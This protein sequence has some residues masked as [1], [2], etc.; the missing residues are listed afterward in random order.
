MP[1]ETVRCYNKGCGAEFVEHENDDSKCVHHPGQPVFHDAMKGWSCCNKK[2]TDFTEFLNIKGCTVGRHSNVK[3][4]EPPKPAA[5]NDTPQE[6]RKSQEETPIPPPNR[7]GPL[8]EL[9]LEISPSL[10]AQ[11]EKAK[12]EAVAAG[13]ATKGTVCKN[14]TCGQ[15][16]EGE[17]S[18]STPCTYHPGTPV[19]HEGMK[20]WSCCERKTSEFDQFMAQKGCSTG[21]HLWTKPEDATKAAPPRT[22]F[23]QTGNSANL[24]VFVKKVDPDATVVKVNEGQ[25]RVLVTYDGGKTFELEGNLNNAIDV[26][27]SRCVVLGSKVEVQMR[28]KYEVAWK[29]L[30]E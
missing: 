3:P 28:K 10:R 17:E 30:L 21:K 18:D 1:G 6:I 12:L 16:Y 9:R 24:C 29:K 25:I 13:V 22:D 2:S 26:S 15:S 14:A 20:Y 11:L 27:Q 19:F 5:Q 7:D 23:F 4:V 8:T